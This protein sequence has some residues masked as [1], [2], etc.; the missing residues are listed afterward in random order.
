ML[1]HSLYRH[2]SFIPTSKVPMQEDTVKDQP[3]QLSSSVQ[4]NSFYNFPFIQKKPSS[5]KHQSTNKESSSSNQQEI[6]FH[7]PKSVDE[8]RPGLQYDWPNYVQKTH[9]TNPLFCALNHTYEGCMHVSCSAL[10]ECRICI[11]A[12][13]FGGIILFN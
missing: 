10:F 2:A 6:L 3:L 7:F 4:R 5:T 9:M 13:Y 1:Q 12:W 8:N 11:L